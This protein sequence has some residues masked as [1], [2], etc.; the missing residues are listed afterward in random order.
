MKGWQRRNVAEIAPRLRV[1]TIDALCASLT[2]QM[3]V[4]ARFGAQPEIVEDARELYI[5]A[6][7]RALALEPQ[8]EP[9][10]R[11]LAHLDNNV[12]TA[13]TLLA[14]MLARRDQWMRKTGAAPGRAELEAAFA[15]EHARL[16]ARARAL[17]PRA[18]VELARE[19]LTTKGTWRARN[20]QAQALADD[21]P[22]RMALVALMALPPENYTDAQWQALSAMLELLPRAAA[23]LKVIFGERGQADFTEIAQGAVRALGEPEA[24]TDLLLSLDVR[25]KHILVDEFQDTSI[26]QWELLERL[27]A[28]WEADDGRTVF[29]VGDP[30]QS[31]YRFREAEVRLFLHARH[32]G[33]GNV[34][35]EP[36][37]L[38]TNFRS[39]A[40]L[41]DWV[42][43]I[44]P[45][46]LPDAED[47]T[48][49]AV[50]YSQSV[51]HHPAKPGDA[52]RWHL[53]DE[54]RDEA[55]CVADIVLE[56]RAKRGARLDCHPRAQSQPPRPYR[57]GAEAG[58]HP[59]PRR[60]NRTPRRET[61]GA[62]SLCARARARAS[63]GPHGMACRAARAVVRA[64]SR[65]PC[66]ARGRRT[67][68][69][70]GTDAR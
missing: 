56:A 16:L 37:R 24:P 7:R 34:P 29:A 31:I 54:R 32:A 8:N 46:V 35:L 12:D 53:F 25:V 39:Q 11:L 62:G 45:R 17:H 67:R 59:L 18:S 52:V 15:A 61:G 38:A 55:K 66:G 63:G 41:V 20:K 36:L 47:E 65:G 21:E 43:T 70:V 57:A 60:R 4:L 42:N 6:A 28:G 27:T 19:L 2:R 49:G 30:M 3:P 9:A 33:L 64:C 40:G 1:Q 5:D 51:A 50:P 10:E 22:L 69:V 13:R 26:S 44:F 68:H 14:A 58:R 48:S 23:Q